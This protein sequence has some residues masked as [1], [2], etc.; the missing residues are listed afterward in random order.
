MPNDITRLL[1]IADNDNINNYNNDD[2]NKCLETS[3]ARVAVHCSIPVDPASVC[4]SNVRE[5]TLKVH[6]RRRVP[7]R[8]VVGL[9]KI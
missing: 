7:S 8:G 1:S 5:K 3:Y 9:G 4:T 6:E 2:N